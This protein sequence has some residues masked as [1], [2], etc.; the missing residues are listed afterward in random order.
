M[1]NATYKALI[2]AVTTQRAGELG[3]TDSATAF[4]S[5]V[6]ELILQPYDLTVDEIDAG[7]T[8]GNGDGQVDAM[9]VLANGA[10][11]T[12]EEEDELPDKGPLEIE[13]VIIQSKYSDGFQENTLKIIRNTAN[14]LIDLKK[15]YAGYLPN[16]SEKLQDAFALARKALVVSAGRTGKVRVRA[17]YA[18][19]GSTANIHPT[20]HTTA[21]VL[22]S[23]LSALTATSDVNLTFVGA[24]ELIELS[25]LPK[26]RNRQLEIQ[27]SISSD[28]GDSFVCL[29]TLGSLVKFLSDDKGALIRSLFDAN[30][31]DF[32]GRTEVNDAIKSTLG[33]L[34]EGD[35]WW[36]NNGITIVASNIDQK[37][38]ILALED[39]LLVNGLQTSNVIF[40]FMTDPG[41]DHDLKEKR[42]EQI[43]LIKIIEPPN[44]KLR[45]EVIKATNSQT[46]IPKPYL[47]GMDR[48]HRN[49]ED[50]LKSYELYYERRKNQYKNAG[51]KRTEIVT[52][53]EVAQSLMAAFLFRPA[54]A[55][56]RP[57]S[58][59]KSDEDYR[60]LFSESYSLDAFRN[61]IVAK[62]LVSARLAAVYPT[63]PATFRNDIVFHVLAYI[64]ARQ[65]H[66]LSHASTGWTT[67]VLDEGAADA[68]IAAVVALFKAAGATDRVAK[69][70]EFQKDVLAAAK[71]DTAESAAAD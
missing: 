71:S 3:S 64:S 11:L 46:H 57:N 33:E 22:R 9:Y 70:P 56:G 41:L 63:E 4:M 32:L 55:R 59:L 68:A 48:V 65:F 60:S 58:L 67:K 6:N 2:E 45:D 54:D 62:R 18:T 52:L 17:F 69:S 27:Q 34:Q 5:V 19:K 15:N 36:F 39:P 47:R 21:S 29:V 61:V 40:S 10:V 23:E 49:I 43:V 14:D 13:L 30:V 42:I 51:K 25:R 28:T 44:E 7:V 26:T 20:V 8:D 24:E 16:Y 53:S 12:G 38:K 50:H 35:F 37:G 31:R 1:S 66:S